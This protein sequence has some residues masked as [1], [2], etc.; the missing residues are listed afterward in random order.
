[1]GKTIKMSD[2]RKQTRRCKT[3]KAFNAFLSRHGVETPLRGERITKKSVAE[4]LASVGRPELAD[5]YEEEW[6]EK[7]PEK[8]TAPSP[9]PFASEPPVLSLSDEPLPS[10]SAPSF[11]NQPLSS[12]SAASLPDEPLLP[13]LI[14][15]EAADILAR[16]LGEVYDDAPPSLGPLVEGGRFVL[17]A[18]TDCIVGRTS[19]DV[20]CHPLTLREKESLKA[21]GYSVSEPRGERIAL[22]RT[23]VFE[24]GAAI[25]KTR[26]GRLEPLSADD[27]THLITEGHAVEPSLQ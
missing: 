2:P 15:T 21:K 3:V 13:V 26:A 11:P 14:E 23:Y 25:G 6:Q 12:G 16:A 17:D 9:P 8:P 22:D 18:V 5:V 20:A 1:M 19:D 10:R 24:Q 4:F 27:L 7:R